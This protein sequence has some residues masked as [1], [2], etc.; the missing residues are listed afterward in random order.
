MITLDPRIEEELGQAFTPQMPA[1]GS[2]ALQPTFIRRVLERCASW[3]VRTLTWRLPSFS[4]RS[5]TRFH[6]RRLLEPFLP[7]IVVHLARRNSRAHSSAFHWE[8][9][10]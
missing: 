4:A 5:H 7:K 2:L 6:L 10:A 9:E 1:S 3:S 8:S